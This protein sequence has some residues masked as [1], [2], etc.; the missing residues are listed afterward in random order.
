MNQTSYRKLC[1]ICQYSQEHTYQNP[2][3]KHSYCFTCVQKQTNL[4]ACFIQKCNAQIYKNEITSFFEGDY[5]P[6]Q[7]DQKSN[8]Q[9]NSNFNLQSSS[10]TSNIYKSKQYV[11]TNES[12]YDFKQ[13]QTKNMRI[14]LTDTQ[15]YCAV[16]LFHIRDD[17]L[18]A[19]IQVNK[20]YPILDCQYHTICVYC[21][22]KF[23]ASQKS[24]QYYCEICSRL[25]K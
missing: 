22:S 25:N 18:Q 15:N 7:E 21:F 8:I 1:D 12:T 19:Q 6:K 3:C 20:N 13:Q 14:E 4:K 23:R 2:I 9:N 16:C 17:F 5:K 10:R 11:T 24:K